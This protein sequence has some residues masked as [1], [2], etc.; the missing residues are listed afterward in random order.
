MCNQ[1]GSAWGP[2][3]FKAPGVPPQQTA[4]PRK[5]AAARARGG[6]L[7]ARR[8]DVLTDASFR[9]GANAPGPGAQRAMGPTLNAHPPAPPESARTHRAAAGS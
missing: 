8:A 6:S 3:P 4:Y 9:H 5:G 1:P 2:A 7:E